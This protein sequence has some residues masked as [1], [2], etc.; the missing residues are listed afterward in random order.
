MNWEKLQEVIIY[1]IVGTALVGAAFVFT[2]L[3]ISV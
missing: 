3:W 1:I 2:L